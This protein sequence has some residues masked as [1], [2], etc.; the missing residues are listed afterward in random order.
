MEILKKITILICAINILGNE[1]QSSKLLLILMDGF[2]WDYIDLPDV[3]LPGFQQMFREGVRA[4]YM[5]SDFPT[6]SYPNYYSIMTGLHCENHGFVG[7]YMYD[8][9]TGKEFLIG[10]NQDMSLPIWWDDGEPL[11]VTAEKQDKSSYLYYWSG[12]EVTIRGVN[13]TYCK[14]WTVPTYSADLTTALSEGLQLFKNNSADLVGIYL[15]SVDRYGHMY[16][17]ASD[18]VKDSLRAVDIVMHDMLSNLSSIGLRDKVNIMIFSDHGMVN[19]TRVVNLTSHLDPDDCVE[20]LPEMNTI[21]IWP[22]PGKTDKSKNPEIDQYVSG[23]MIGMHGFD[24]SNEEM[25]AFFAA[26][27]PAFKKN[28]VH[29]PIRNVELYQIMCHILGIKPAPNNGTWSN[30]KDMLNLGVSSATKSN[31]D[32]SVMTSFSVVIFFQCILFFQF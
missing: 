19:R 14:A 11:W 2:R 5:V 10:G 17:A 4:K 25:R 3:P 6:T 9:A 7:N 8:V 27:G 20:I 22:K 29:R 28:V 30:V 24:T 15:Q 12:C 13:P 21:G 18:K 23:P 1:V 31:I 32:V 26:S 16:G